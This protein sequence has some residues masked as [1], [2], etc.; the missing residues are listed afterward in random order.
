MKLKSNMVVKSM[1]NIEVIK[2]PK[3]LRIDFINL[4]NKPL[5][6]YL[7]I[8][9]IMLQLEDPTFTNSKKTIRDLIPLHYKFLTNHYDLEPHELTELND[10]FNQPA[11]VLL[12]YLDED[13]II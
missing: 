11:E 1:I 9:F 13:I 4:S 12:K 2:T 8:E 7:N 10:W 6:Q 3:G 5:P